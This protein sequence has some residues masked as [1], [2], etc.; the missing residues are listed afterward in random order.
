MRER[1]SSCAGTEGDGHSWLAT[2]HSAMVP[3]EA[4]AACYPNIDLQS[5]ILPRL[6]LRTAETGAGRRVQSGAATQA[7]NLV[8]NIVTL[9]SEIHCTF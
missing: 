6:A 7:H 1:G 9:F 2:P 3:A 8:T 4:A 5:I